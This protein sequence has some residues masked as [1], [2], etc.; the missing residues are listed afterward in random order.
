MK[1][2]RYS[3]LLLSLT[4]VLHIG[5]ALANFGTQYKS[6]LADGLVNVLSD[7]GRALAFWF[8]IVGALLILLG[9]CLS[10][11]IR[12]SGRPAPPFLGYTL[13]A[14]SLIGC[15]VVPVSGFWLFIPQALI[16]IWAQFSK[17]SGNPNATHHE[18]EK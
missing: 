8:L 3:G 10:R 16:I 9:E 7:T 14:I 17:S 1:L 11:Y 15:A 2:W 13:L 12:Q 4:G 18:R 6:M 5:V